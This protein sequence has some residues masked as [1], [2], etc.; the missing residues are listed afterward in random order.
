MNASEDVEKPLHVMTVFVF[1]IIGMV[2]FR[3]TAA[4]GERRPPCSWSTTFKNTGSH[5]TMMTI[6]TYLTTTLNFASI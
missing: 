1:A 5:I 6:P 3:P 4:A 2:M